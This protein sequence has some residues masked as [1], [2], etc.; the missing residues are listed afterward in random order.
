M[1]DKER[2][3]VGKKL[4]LNGL[5]PLDD[6]YRKCYRLKGKDLHELITR[7]PGYSHWP[8]PENLS[9]RYLTEEVPNLLV[10]VS[11]FGKLTNTK[12]P[13]IDSFIHFAS[14]IN[15]TDYFKKGRNLD[16]LGFTGMSLEEIIDSL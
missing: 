4:N 3:E 8:A 5:I 9:H 2:I 16:V 14:I 10:P 6:W 11:S 1:V 13:T 7:N 12:T 15:E